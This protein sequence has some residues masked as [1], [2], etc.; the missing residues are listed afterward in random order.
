MHD[1]REVGSLR[2]KSEGQFRSFLSAL[3]VYVRSGLRLYTSFLKNSLTAMALSWERSVCS[4]KTSAVACDIASR[5]PK[6]YSSCE[7]IKGMR[8]RLSSISTRKFTYK[9]W[10]SRGTQFCRSYIVKHTFLCNKELLLT[11]CASCN[12]NRGTEQI[13]WI[14][15][16]EE[17]TNSNCCK[18]RWPAHEVRSLSVN[19]SRRQ[20]RNI[21]NWNGTSS[22]GN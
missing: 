8:E 9:Y 10:N 18:Y 1:S 21:F 22:C 19:G 14:T 3:C 12:S 13:A 5:D 2:L 20:T 16:S 6:P 11:E 7:V 4:F 17:L 15:A